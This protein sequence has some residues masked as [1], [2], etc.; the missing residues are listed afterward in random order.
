MYGHS[1]DF[2]GRISANPALNIRWS[3]NAPKLPTINVATSVRWT[4]LGFLN[5]WGNRLSLSYLNTRQE[6]Y[7]SNLK[8][9]LFDMRVG[10]RNEYISI[11]NIRSFEFIGDYD[12]GQLSNDFVT[13]F[14]EGRADTFDDGYFPAKGVNAGISYVWTFAG[15]PHRFNNFHT[16]QVDAKTVVPIGDRLAF[17]PS[18]NFR[19]LFG[20]DVPVAYFN[21]IGGSLQG[22]YLDQQIPFLGVTNL[23]AMKNFLTIYRADLRLRLAKNHY[24][25]GTVNYARDCDTL[26]EYPYGSGYTGAALEYSFDTIFGPLSANVHWSDLTRKVGFYLSAGYSF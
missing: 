8:W 17:I 14:A 11:R 24:L 12:F 18:F 6:M 7:I 19:F 22:R 13:A 20:D 23:H 4:D 9:K 2:T 10:A 3:Y 16:V 15:F 26:K 21:A 25:T 1:F 5:I